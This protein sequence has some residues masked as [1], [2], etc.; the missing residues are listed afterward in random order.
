M[1]GVGTELT[2]IQKGLR[3]TIK[4]GQHPTRGPRDASDEKAR[5]GSRYVRWPILY[6]HRTS[7]KRNP[8]GSD[9]RMTCIP[10]AAIIFFNLQLSTEGQIEDLQTRHGPAAHSHRPAISISTNSP[11]GPQ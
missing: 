7:S 10:G 3:L 4:T 11:G 1:Q 5:G 6:F 8:F 2:G 9:A